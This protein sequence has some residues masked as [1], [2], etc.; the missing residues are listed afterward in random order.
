MGKRRLYLSRR[1]LFIHHVFKG[2]GADVT[3]GGVVRGGCVVFSGENIPP[4][5]APQRRVLVY[6]YIRGV[7]D[8]LIVFRH[9]PITFDFIFIRRLA[10]FVYPGDSSHDYRRETPVYTRGCIR[11]LGSGFIG[12][13][14]GT[15]LLGGGLVYRASTRHRSRI[16]IPRAGIFL[17]HNDVR[18]F[19]RGRHDVHSGMCPACRDL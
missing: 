5:F 11:F 8:N 16:R 7:V 12:L 13:W 1:F 14:F 10:I 6:M 19:L 15:T 2:A 9:Q 3:G 18:Q 4:A 17:K